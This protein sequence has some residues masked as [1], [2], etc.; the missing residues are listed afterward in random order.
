M[1]TTMQ[2]PDA[3][4][5][6][7]SR[8]MQ[9]VVANG[10]DLLTTT[11]LEDVIQRQGGL[12]ILVETPDALVAAVDYHFPV[13]VLV[14]LNLAGDWAGAI[15][16]CK[17]RPHTR[18]I[19]IY[20][21]GSHV[22]TATLAAARKAG[23]DHAWARS[24]MMEE[25]SSLLARHLHPPVRYPEGWNEP[26]QGEALR[27]VE[28]FNAGHYFEQH[29]HFEAAWMAEPR[30]IRDFYQGILQVGVAFLQIE[31][32]NW[33]GALKMF[34]RGLP[35]LRD[36]PPV[37]QGIDLASLRTIA[38]VIHQEI[39]ALGPTRLAEFDQSKF[40]KIRMVKGE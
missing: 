20:A 10:M 36:L 2:T 33:A 26:L 16:R 13:L 34:R 27:G 12:P 30:L 17:L 31:Q 11:R 15:H 39:T 40:P 24:R 37:C 28:E 5:A 23:A 4:A 29:E 25:L 9:P 14:D 7:S 32:G 3:P 6:T 1:G 22:D 8:P 21:Y 18:Q 38:E 19:P 35:R